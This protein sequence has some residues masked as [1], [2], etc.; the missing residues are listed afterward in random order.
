M[1]KNLTM[2]KLL[3]KHTWMSSKDGSY[4]VCSVCREKREPTRPTYEELLGDFSKVVAG[5]GG[6]NY[7]GL[8]TTTGGGGG[9]ALTI[10]KMNEVVESMWNYDEA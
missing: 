9:G 4:Q 7:T 6:G 10:N 5:G 1:K 3:D 8:S 2:H